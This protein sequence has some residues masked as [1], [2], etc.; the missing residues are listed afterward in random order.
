MPKTRPVQRTKAWL[1][2]RG[3]PCW[4]VEKYIRYAPGDPRKKIRPGERQDMFGIIDVVALYPDYICGIQC[5][6]GSGNAGHIRKLM[7][8]RREESILW[9]SYPYTKL[10]V[11]SWRQLLVKRGGKRKRWEPLVTVIDADDLKGGT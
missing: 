7:E 11:H 10:E 5:G 2:E 9:T 3:I 8:E 4:V 1:K 6:S